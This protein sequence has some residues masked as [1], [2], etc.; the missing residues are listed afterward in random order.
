MNLPKEKLTKI[1]EDICIGNGFLSRTLTV[2]E[3]ISR[4][5]KCNYIELNFFCT[6]KKTTNKESGQLAEWKKNVSS[7]SSCR[8]LI[9]RIYKKVKKIKS[10]D[11]KD[12]NYYV[13]KICTKKGKESR[14]G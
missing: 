11:R 3:I 2:R 12:C 9:S 6:A 1:L 4:I 8:R 14:Y 7:Y 10:P 5:S 13:V